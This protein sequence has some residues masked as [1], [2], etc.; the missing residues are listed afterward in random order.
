MNSLRI[1]ENADFWNTT[2]KKKRTTNQTLVHVAKIMEI[3]SNEGIKKKQKIYWRANETTGKQIGAIIF[4][5]FCIIQTAIIRRMI[6]S[7]SSPCFHSICWWSKRPECFCNKTFKRIASFRVHNDSLRNIRAPI[8][9][10]MLFLNTFF[11][12]FFLPFFFFLFFILFRSLLL[13][14]CS[15]SIDLLRCFFFF[16]WLNMFIRD[17]FDN[18][19]LKSN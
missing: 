3:Q 9:L 12:S 14:F 19:S 4:R 5:F 13:E 15:F 1:S 2:E 7:I 10:T 8:W 16:L 17:R 6:L 11:P 18:I